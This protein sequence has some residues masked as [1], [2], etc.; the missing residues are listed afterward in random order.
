MGWLIFG[1]L[2][3]GGSLG[4]LGSG[5]SIL[6]VPVL[7][8]VLDRPEK[9]AIAESLAIVGSISLMGAISHAVKSQIHWPTVVWFGLTGMLGAYLGAYGSSFVSSRCQIIC[10]AVAMLAAAVTMF[11]S[12]PARI[13][14]VT[15][16]PS[17]LTMMRNGFFVGGL[18]GFVGMGG[19][20][21]I[22]PA[23]VLFGQLPMHLAVGTSLVIIALN[24]FTGFAEQFFH[25]RRA[26]LHVSWHVIALMA[27][28]GI[29]G[30]FIG[31]AMSTRITAGQLR[32]IFGVF[33]T[34]VS[35]YLLLL[36]VE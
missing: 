7:L 34:L 23:L 9:L 29:C 36:G 28:I 16:S 20:F 11:F 10:F 30:S 35:I 8:L 33:I 31:S 25:L 1:A 5:G 18:T 13:Q 4:L 2:A 12:A 32:K 22:V 19:G 17:S 24:A 26:D 27:P 6:T 14:G 3:I 15:G 21:L